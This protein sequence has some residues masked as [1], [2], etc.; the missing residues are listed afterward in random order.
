[1][2]QRR[3]RPCNK[4]TWSQPKEMFGE[5]REWMPQEFVIEKS[6]LKIRVSLQIDRRWQMGCEM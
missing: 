1:M 6:Y 2:L 5:I 4:K 3:R